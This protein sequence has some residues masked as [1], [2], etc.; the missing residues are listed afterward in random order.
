MVMCREI[1]RMIVDV[2]L[3]RLSKNAFLLSECGVR[4]G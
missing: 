2:S 3:A 1:W 4:I